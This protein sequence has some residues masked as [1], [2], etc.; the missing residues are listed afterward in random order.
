MLFISS[1][2]LFSFPRCSNF[3][4]SILPSFFPVDHCFRG[5]SKLILKVYDVINCLNKNLMTYFVWYLEKEKRYDIETLSI[6]RVLNKR[7]FYKKSR[8]KPAPKASPRSLLVLANNPKQPSHARNSFRGGFSLKRLFLFFLSNPVLFKGQDYE[9]QKGSETK[10]SPSS[11]YK[12]D[13]E[14][15]LY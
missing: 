10:T 4:V 6:E 14:K 3:C 15:F 2:R 9:K 5:W 11:S 13:S 12:T 1:T 7:G 8:R